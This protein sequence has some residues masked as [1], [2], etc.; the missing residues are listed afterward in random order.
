MNCE[1]GLTLHDE[2]VGWIYKIIG[3]VLQ[4]Q[5]KFIDVELVKSSLAKFAQHTN[6]YIYTLV[7]RSLELLHG[8]LRSKFL[9]ELDDDTLILFV[10][11]AC[12]HLI[13][14]LLGV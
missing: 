2:Y 7:K 6:L 1:L 8:L 9:C 12:P 11:F 5:V 3:C 14:H 10:W 4:S 13:A